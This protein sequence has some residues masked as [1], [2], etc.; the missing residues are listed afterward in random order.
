[1]ITLPSD[2]NTDSRCGVDKT[3]PRGVDIN[4]EGQ[5]LPRSPDFSPA[6]IYLLHCRSFFQ[7]RVDHPSIFRCGDEQNTSY[8][9]QILDYLGIGFKESLF[10]TEQSFE[11]VKTMSINFTSRLEARIYEHEN[12]LDHT[13][14]ISP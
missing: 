2:S 1:M 8:R 12:P 11:G 4:F 10:T 5:G 13:P 6:A 7:H 3:K 14:Q 9:A